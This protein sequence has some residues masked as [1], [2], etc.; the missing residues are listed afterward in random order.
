MFTYALSS[1][2]YDA[3]SAN[4]PE[5]SLAKMKSFQPS[6]IIVDL[7]MPL[8]N[9]LEVARLLR[10]NGYQHPFAICSAFME[11]LV[12]YEAFELGIVDFISKPTT[13]AALRGVAKRIFDAKE[14]NYSDNF[15]E[16]RQQI[17]EREFTKAKTNCEKYLAEN[18]GDE[19]VLVLLELLSYQ[20]AGDQAQVQP[21][22]IS[23]LLL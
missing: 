23:A 21:V 19:R 20:A 1:D 4:G 14:Q 6:L 8:M 11:K 9:G 17:R 12:L 16:V 7:Q 10:E 13:P 5:E 18:E 3:D 2:G 22:D 15:E